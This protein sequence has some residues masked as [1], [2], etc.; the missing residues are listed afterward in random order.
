MMKNLSRQALPLIDMP[1]CILSTESFLATQDRFNGLLLEKRSSINKTIDPYLYHKSCRL[2]LHPQTSYY[3]D[4]AFSQLGKFEVWNA[5]SKSRFF[6]DQKVHLYNEISLLFTDPG[7]WQSSKKA[8][9]LAKAPIHEPNNKEFF[10][11]VTSII[12]LTRAF[13]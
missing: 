2:G 3:A 12:S 6:A 11:R 8:G 7:H 4:L 5:T 1:S 10:Y 9:M 13:L